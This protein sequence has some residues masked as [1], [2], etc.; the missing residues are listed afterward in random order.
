MRVSPAPV[1]RLLDFSERGFGRTV[2]ALMGLGFLAIIGAGATAAWIQVETQ[3]LTERVEQTREIE[4]VL[5]LFSAANER[6]ETARRGLLINPAGP[7]ANTYRNSRAEIEPLLGRLSDSIEDPEQ[8]QRL[9][10]LKALL[11]RLRQL[12]DRSIAY[13]ESG[14][15]EEARAAFRTDEANRLVRQG[16]VIN[17]ELIAA[18][19]DLLSIRNARQR[20]SLGLFYGVLTVAGILL[21]VVAV[22]SIFVIM[23]YTRDLARSRDDLGNLN[24]NLERAVGART[25][26]LQR[27]NDEIQRFAYIV[28]HDLRSP[29][30]NV[31][32]FTAELDTARGQIAEFVD[33]LEEKQPDL[34]PNDIKLAAKEDLPEAIGFIRT[35]TQK[36]DR[37]INSILK[38]S[39]EGRRT[40]SSEPIDMDDM[41]QQIADSLAHRVDEGGARIE[42]AKPLP[43]VTSDRLAIEQ[44]FSNLIE[45]AV[46]YL[47]PGRP[48]VIAVRGRSEGRRILFEIEDNGRGID[49]RDHQ[50]VFDLFRRSGQQD[51]P[52]EGIGLAHVR[53]LAYRLGGLV[54]CESQLDT[55]ATFRISLPQTFQPEQ[56]ATS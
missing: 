50:R 28:S 21:L 2:I 43:R 1:M 26:D 10:N 47:K 49:P 22:A 24:A 17:A 27:A 6:T 48:G 16:R 40:I 8:R 18:E 52:G 44:I 23:R 36:M 51:Q 15:I 39:R 14:A 11:T 13:V 32:G 55:G 31:M 46:K 35:S 53:A 38:L 3:Q 12:Q 4:S 19:Q 41:V 37:L 33:D 54:D 25:E 9:A 20:Q 5:A 29:L 42:I 30:V 7:F 56:R 45:N 34:V